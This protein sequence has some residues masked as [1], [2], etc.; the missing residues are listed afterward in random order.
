MPRG[1]NELNKEHI[2]IEIFKA[3]KEVFQQARTQSFN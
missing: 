3:L 2:K 1:F